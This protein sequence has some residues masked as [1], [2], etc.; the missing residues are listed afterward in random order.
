MYANPKIMTAKYTL[1]ML[2]MVDDISDMV[3]FKGILYI[4]VKVMSDFLA[5]QTM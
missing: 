4:P 5:K 1:Y 3:D 2:S